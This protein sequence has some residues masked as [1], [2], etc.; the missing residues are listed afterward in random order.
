MPKSSSEHNLAKLDDLTS[1]QITNF[2]GPMNRNL[3]IIEAALNTRLSFDN[4][5]LSILTEANQL[6]HVR[7]TIEN[8]MQTSIDESLEPE[9]L[10][11]LL[12]IASRTDLN[13]LERHTIQLKK[14]YIKP[15][16]AQQCQYIKG[17]E[18]KVVNFGIGPAGTGKT[19]LAVA[20]A[21]KALEQEEVSRL[22]LTRPA[23]EAGEKLGIFT[24]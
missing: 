21:V 9:A 7:S 1:D 5:S 6:S 11:N 3:K 8:L 22:I 19:Y 23:V 13:D 15:K 16:S 4:G 20:M 10:K 17:I 14:K 12:R 2:C 24:W 18:K